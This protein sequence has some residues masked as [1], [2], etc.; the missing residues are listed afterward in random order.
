MKLVGTPQYHDYNPLWVQWLFF[1]LIILRLLALCKSIPRLQDASTMEWVALSI[2]LYGKNMEMWYT[3]SMHFHNPLGSFSRSWLLPQLGK[4]VIFLW[5][6][7]EWWLY[8]HVVEMFMSLLPHR[9]LTCLFMLVLIITL[10][11]VILCILF[12]LGK[13]HHKCSP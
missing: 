13:I 4:L 12:H 7:G 9:C 11:F 3:Q 2:F 6:A 5:I 8:Q 10:Q 1:K